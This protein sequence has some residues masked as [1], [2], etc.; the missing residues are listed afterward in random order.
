[1]TVSYTAAT[2]DASSSNAAIQDTVGHDA[3]SLVNQAVTVMLSPLVLDLNDDHSMSVADSPQHLFQINPSAP[4]MLQGW[5]SK[6]DAF[7][8]RDLNANHMIDNGTE[9]LGMGT[10][11]PSGQ[12]AQDGFQALQ[13]LDANQDGVIN[14]LDQAFSELGLW[15]DA[16]GNGVTDVGELTSLAHHNIVQ[17]NLNPHTSQVVDHGNLLGLISSYE[18]GDGQIHDLVDVF[19]NAQQGASALVAAAEHLRTSGQTGAEWI[20]A[21][22]EAGFA[23]TRAGGMESFRM[24]DD[25]ASVL[26]QS[27]FLTADANARIEVDVSAADSTMHL[28]LKELA[29][30][31]V[32][33]VHLGGH[34]TVDLGASS[35]SRD[36]LS[37]LLDTLQGQRTGAAQALFSG[38]GATL[39]MDNAVMSDLLKGQAEADPMVDAILQ[40]LRELGVTQLDGVEMAHV[41]ASQP[42]VAT[43]SA[44]LVSTGV[45]GGIEAQLLGQP[46]PQDLSHLLD[47][48]ILTKPM[49]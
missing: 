14:S 21:L 45:G 26:V 7:L 6:D 24:A 8:I 22:S 38:P 5:V 44:L 3:A 32:D 13:S 20:Q 1:V 49:V 4:S 37:Q 17:L 30:V 33:V 35:L 34:A 15:Q 31:G 9:L 48:D 2:A 11:L 12:V 18:T 39:V 47:H 27:G 36:E 19:F 16:N 40:S 46:D 43:Q 41:S 42:A 28:S 25:L 10:L 29:Q 23:P